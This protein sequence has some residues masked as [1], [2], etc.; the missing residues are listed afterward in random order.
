MSHTI[1]ASRGCTHVVVDM[2]GY[3]LSSHKSERAAQAA[4]DRELAAFRRSPYSRGGA[5][6][7]RSIIAVGEDGQATISRCGQYSTSWV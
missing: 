2:D 5:Y 4:I 7:P 1:T 3:A 6:L